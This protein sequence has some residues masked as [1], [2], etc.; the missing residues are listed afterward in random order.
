MRMTLVSAAFCLCFANST[1][2]APNAPA[3]PVSIRAQTVNDAEWSDKA[4]Q[5]TVGPMTV[6][7]QVLLDRAHFSPGEIDGKRGE[8]LDKAI[9]AYAAA[10]GANSGMSTELWQKLIEMFKG[11]VIVGY[12]IS[13]GDVK[14]PFA[15]KIPEKMEDMKDLPA[16]SYINPKEQ[17]AEKFHMSPELLVSL[18]PDQ[19]KFDK[20]G[21]TIMVAS[22]ASAKLSEK[23]VK[24]EVDKGKQI[25]K[26]LGKAKALLAVYPVTAGS[27][28]KPAPDGI[29]KVTSIAANPTYR[30]N[31]DYAFKGVKSQEAFTIKPG[32]NNPVGLAWIGLNKEG[33]GIHG[34]PEPSKISKSESHGC[35]RLTN[36]DA[37][38]LAS[39][40][41]K[42]VPVE[43]IGDEKDRPLAQAQK[44]KGKRSKP[45]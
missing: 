5:E 4:T 18:N 13:E 6:K 10:Q 15:E 7:L 22:V 32:P 29:L 37:L 24:I 11:P 43:F 45:R 41:T 16:L 34:T 27:T 21:A 3:L 35:I 31:P 25:L 20:A 28:E 44:R 1:V 8:N 38:Q 14:G 33:Y 42:G 26:V 12:K 2:A 17:L 40:I 39:T 36:W 23:A 9:A 19:Q 30:Y